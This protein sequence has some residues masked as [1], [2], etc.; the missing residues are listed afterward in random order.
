MMLDDLLY[1]SGMAQVRRPATPAVL[2]LVSASDKPRDGLSWPAAAAGGRSDRPAVAGGR[3]SLT[4]RADE[5]VH[6]PG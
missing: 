4:S 2:G 6:A 3:S 5:M 1:G